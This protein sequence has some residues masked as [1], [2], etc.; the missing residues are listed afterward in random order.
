MT[1]KPHVLPI[2]IQLCDVLDRTFIETVGPFGELVVSEARVEWLAAGARI[3]TRDIEDYVALL[4]REV[5]DADAR[6]QFL[7]AARAVIGK[8]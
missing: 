7:A 1:H 8:Y 6:R 3:R 5:N 2:L 4:A